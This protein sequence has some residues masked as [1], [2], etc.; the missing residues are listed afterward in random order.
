MTRD[1]KRYNEEK[2]FAGG[3]CDYH[4]LVSCIEALRAF[5]Q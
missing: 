4:T 1:N 2:A 3:K 5:P